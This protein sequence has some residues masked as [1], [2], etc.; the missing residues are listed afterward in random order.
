MLNLEIDAP[1]NFI[2]RVVIGDLGITSRGYVGTR[3]HVAFSCYIAAT[4][5]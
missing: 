1:L 3:L 2:L 4:G 5:F